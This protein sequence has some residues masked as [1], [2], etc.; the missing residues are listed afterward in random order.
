MFVATRIVNGLVAMLALFMAFLLL[1]A[2]PSATAMLMIVVFG[3]VALLY[4][5]DLLLRRKNTKV[6][7]VFATLWTL[8]FLYAV[9]RSVLVLTAGIPEEM[10]GD[11]TTLYGTL[12]TVYVMPFV[13]NGIYL[14]RLFSQKES[15][16]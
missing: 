6:D 7:T 2:L 5:F 1:P 10:A 12:I 9:Y 8:I 3:F 13:L 14:L 16:A 11:T 15:T 4:V